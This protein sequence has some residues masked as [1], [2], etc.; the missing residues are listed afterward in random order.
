MKELKISL[1]VAVGLNNE[2]GICNKLPWKSPSDLKNFKEITENGIIIMGRK[3][4]ES[5]PKLL[6]N[7]KHIV[8]TRKDKNNLVSTNSEVL[9]YSSIEEALDDCRNKEIERV[10]II[11]GS[12]I[13]KQVIDK[14]L[15][16]ELYITSIN[17][18]GTADKF[19]PKIDLNDWDLESQLK[20]ESTLEDPLTWVFRKYIKNTKGN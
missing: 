14:D 6:P 13:Y 19:F 17:W 11:G 2:I 9:F 5:L 15:I 16:N 10:F 18:T 7:R 8:I 1:I 12:S 20:H 4:F 3:T